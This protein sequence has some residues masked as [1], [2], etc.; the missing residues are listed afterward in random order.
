MNPVL[1]S[2]HSLPEQEKESVEITKSQSH[3]VHPFHWVSGMWVFMRMR[4]DR[5]TSWSIKFIKFE[6]LYNA[7]EAAVAP[8]RIRILPHPLDKLTNSHIIHSYYTRTASTM[9]S[10]S[11]LSLHFHNSSIHPSS[12]ASA[13]SPHPHRLPP[14]SAHAHTSI[15]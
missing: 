8:F 4:I 9:L 15:I 3:N 2:F 11:I 13:S 14:P 1:S 12:S 10:L 7:N 5:F 6:L